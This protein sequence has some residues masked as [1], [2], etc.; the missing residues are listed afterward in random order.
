MTTSTAIAKL[1][2]GLILQYA[3]TNPSENFN[4]QL[5]GVFRK[6]FSAEILIK[7]LDDFC[8]GEDLL[9]MT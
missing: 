5:K 6:P 7:K 8:N 2:S 9:K 3:T 4:Q 1:R